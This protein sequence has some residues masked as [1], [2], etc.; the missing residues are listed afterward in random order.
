MDI[1]RGKGL[2][3]YV[4]IAISA[5]E[6]KTTL[7]NVIENIYFSYAHMQQHVSRNSRAVKIS[8]PEMFLKIPKIG[9]QIEHW[10]LSII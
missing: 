4:P 2:L 10:N 1:I 9:V 8:L 5:N 6:N 7:I 3:K